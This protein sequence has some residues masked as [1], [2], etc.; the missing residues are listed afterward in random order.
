MAPHLYQLDTVGHPVTPQVRGEH[1]ALA[2]N[3]LLATPGSRLM[4]LELPSLNERPRV[5]GN[6]LRKMFGSDF[7]G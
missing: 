5:R 2:D 7:D 3:A 6:K 1:A 4:V